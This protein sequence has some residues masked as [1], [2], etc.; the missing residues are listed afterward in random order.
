MGPTLRKL[1]HALHFQRMTLIWCQHQ[2]EKYPCLIWW[3]LR[4]YLV[5]FLLNNFADLCLSLCISS[6]YGREI[7]IFFYLQTMTTFKPPPPAATYLAFHPHD[8]NI[9]AIGMEDAVVQIYNVRMDEVFYWELLPIIIFHDWC[10]SSTYLPP[11][12]VV[13]HRQ[14]SSSKVIIKE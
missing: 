14:E 9:V 8:N 13:L 2:E 3:H 1:F 6:P 11:L 10:K 7:L 4:L 5:V 12:I